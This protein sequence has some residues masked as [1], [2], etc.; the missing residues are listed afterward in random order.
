MIADF[1]KQASK[2]ASRPA[3]KEKSKRTQDIE[4]EE[5]K[6]KAEYGKKK[7][8]IFKD[9]SGGGSEGKIPVGNI[10]SDHGKA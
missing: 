8:F 4:K 1:R 6:R 2:Q 9:N 7:K 3:G 5:S 10:G